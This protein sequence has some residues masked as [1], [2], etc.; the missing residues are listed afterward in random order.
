MIA[1]TTV[2]ENG[3]VVQVNQETLALTDQLG[4]GLIGVVYKAKSIKS[5]QVFA[6]KRARARFNFFHQVLEIEKKVADL[7]SQASSLKPARILEFTSNSLLKE[8]HP[9]P[10]LQSLLLENKLT[11]KQKSTLVAVLEEAAEINHKY[12]FILDL[13]AKNLAWKN[14]WILLDSGPKSHVTDFS[15]VL[16]DPTWDN[17]VSYLQEKT[18]KQKISAPSVLSKKVDDQKILA[19]N[20]FFVQ[21]WWLWL[22]FDEEVPANYYYI[23]I[24]ENQK[25]TEIIFSL[26]LTEKIIKPVSQ[27][28]QE[29]L[30]N[31]I[32]QQ[33]ALATWQKQY[34]EIKVSLQKVH[35]TAFSPL[36]LSSKPINLATIASQAYPLAMAKALKTFVD[37]KEF[38]E[39]PTL[40]VNSYTHWSDLLT[41]KKDFLPTDIYCH[42]PLHTSLKW[43]N[44]FLSQ[45]PYFVTTPP[46]IHK[47]ALCELICIPSENTDRA[48]IFLPGFRASAKAAIPLIARLKEKGLEA[49]CIAAQIGAFNPQRQLL[50]TGGVWESLLLWQIIDYAIDC[51]GVKEVDIIAASYGAI[52]AAIVAQTHPLVKRLVLDSSVIKPYDLLIYLSKIQGFEPE[53]MLKKAKEHR[54]GEPFE[55]T[56]PKRKGLSTLTMRPLNDRFMD[57]CGHLYLDK[58]FFYD[59]GHAATMRHD[60]ENK[61]IPEICL[62]MIFK[63]LTK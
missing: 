5:G 24:D 17:Y 58:T 29:F 36:S 48:I 56:M 15:K 10:T 38:L 43:T 6:Y 8:F 33:T 60:I 27:A 50:L 35:D 20:F 14:S 16:K 51:L 26:N 42:I 34:P 18:T 7:L 1:S 21:D 59:S 11:S 40:T 23:T 46:N 39:Q 4:S 44:Q 57:I 62:E 54:L 45:T 30:T 31:P 19:E 22:P 37:K 61:E 49:M 52:A 3:T 2:L 63:F 53:E 47:D 55:V 32:L 28:A 13:S 9:E 25:E 12:N 41:N